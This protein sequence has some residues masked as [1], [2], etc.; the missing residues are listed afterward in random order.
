MPDP[1]TCTHWDGTAH[2][3]C[4]AVPARLY[5]PGPRCPAHTPAALAGRPEPQPGRCAPNR[6][7]GGC[8]PS[9]RPDT[10]HYVAGETWAAVDARAIASGKRRASPAVQAA[11]KAT[12]AEQ[13]Q[14][15]AN[16]RNRP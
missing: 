14:R 8:C 13:R 6:C 12:I 10:V 15:D 11:A 1:L 9:W 16:L 7:Y 4:G 3:L 5:L 2:V